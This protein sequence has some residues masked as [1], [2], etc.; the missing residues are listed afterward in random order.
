MQNNISWPIIAGSY[1][2]GD[3]H[4]SVAVCVLTSER[5][6][7]PL[8]H[9]SGVVITG[10]VYT[11][12]LGI[13]HIAM[14]VITNPA[15]RFLL[16]CGKD[17]PPF[18]PG[19]S[20]VALAERGVDEHQ[21]IIGALG[22]EPI[23]QTLTSEQIAL[24]R[25]QIEVVDWTGEEDVSALASRI[26]SLAARNPGPFTSSK[27]IAV[28]NL[29]R[30]QFTSIQPGGQRE[31]LQYDPKGYFV[32][33]LDRQAEQIVLRHYHSDHT[34]AHE[35]RGRSASS[36]FLGLIREGLVTQLSHAG[37]LGEELAKA[38]V[39][40]LHGWRYEQDRPLRPPESTPASSEI[41][42]GNDATP[43]GPA[44]PPS[45]A[46]ISPPLRWIEL[47]GT[48][49]GATIDVVFVITD[50]PA[51]ELLVGDFLEPDEAE[52]FSAYRRTSHQLQVR[53]TGV[54][55]IAMGERNDV[56]V[57]TVV[58]IRGTFSNDRAIDAEQM[59]ILSNVVRIIEP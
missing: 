35:M 27:A 48:K 50:Q 1:E 49:P 31:P 41:T 5:L 21:Q 14:N 7:A 55:R 39:A 6:I 4:G 42:S 34:S 29:N 15:I 38:Q 18:R 45:K 33:T 19:Q 11:A 43:T 47:E 10:K 58:R 30:E 56:H 9:L 22:Y 37:Y 32:I 36:M 2:I 53:W 17:S 23:L 13:E 20:L 12:N 54:T 3:I 52:L 44:K 24:F 46:N 51:S 25:Q 59:V 40:L 57:N 8:A 28:T 16:L 26:A